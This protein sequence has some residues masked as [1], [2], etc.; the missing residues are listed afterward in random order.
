MMIPGLVL[1]IPKYQIMMKLG[2]VDTYAGL[3]IPAAA[4]PFGTFLMRQFMLTIPRS[5]DEAAE[6]DGASK[7]QVF[8][9]VVLP[10]AR[11][12][13]IVLL[14]FQFM[15]A[16]KG[17]IWPLIMLRS[18]AKY[19]LPVGMLFFESSRGTEPQLVMAAV[20]MT[21]VPLIILFVVLQKYLVKGIQL[22]AVKG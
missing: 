11:P 4:M 7:W 16:Y 3:I 12:G 15:G 20:T 19:T 10:L 5:L 21:I 13:L 9:D 22:G 14:L 17:F 2:W 6:I 1:M 18:Q 8:W